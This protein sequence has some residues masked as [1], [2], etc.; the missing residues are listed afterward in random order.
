M[1]EHNIQWEPDDFFE[2]M[3]RRMLTDKGRRRLNAA[4]ASVAHKGKPKRDEARAA[5]TARHRAAREAKFAGVL[6]ATID[7]MRSEGYGV[8]AIATFIRSTGTS[9]SAD[10]IRNRLM[11]R[12]LWPFKTRRG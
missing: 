1:N 7:K 2:V 11:D 3:G 8:E 12:G 6:D 9:V 10:A 5:L 4:R